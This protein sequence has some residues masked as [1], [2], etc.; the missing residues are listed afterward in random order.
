MMSSLLA[1]LSHYFLFPLLFQPPCALFQMSRSNVEIEITVRC[2]V[3][4]IRCHQTRLVSILSLASASSA[5][6][7]RV[8]ASDDSEGIDLPTL[9]EIIA[10]L[11]VNLRQHIDRYRT[12]LGTNL[13]TM[14]Y[15]NRVL[16]NKRSYQDRDSWM[17]LE[18]KQKQ[19]VEKRTLSVSDATMREIDGNMKKKKKKKAKS[20]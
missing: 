20:E 2:V 8:G 11:K 1:S 3:F 12:L 14:K 17:A 7:T 19:R 13:V 5:L 16:E 9:P 15:M 6:I 10:E 4:L 18:G